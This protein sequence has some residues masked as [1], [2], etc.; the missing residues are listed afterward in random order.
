MKKRVLFVLSAFSFFTATA[1]EN[2]WSARTSVDGVVR[3]QAT[4]RQ[5]FPTDYKLFNLSDVPLRQEIFKV[6][7]NA[8]KHSTI[9]SIPNAQGQLE[10]FEI[11]EASNFEPQ[12]QAQFPNIRAFSGKG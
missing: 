2:Y 10:Q 1:Q 9:I 6:I 8:T 4:T 11:F 12:L 3:A 7:D 5:S